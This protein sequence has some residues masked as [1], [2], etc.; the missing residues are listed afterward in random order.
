M[1]C[2]GRYTLFMNRWTPL[3]YAASLLVLA[4]VIAY[5]VALES[6]WK[7]GEVLRRQSWLIVGLPLHIA[8]VL[9]GLMASLGA[10]LGVLVAGLAGLMICLWSKDLSDMAFGLRDRGRNYI[11]VRRGHQAGHRRGMAA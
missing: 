4:V 7:M 10:R 9:L 11:H 6:S 2:H 8:L 3:E 1:R 5:C